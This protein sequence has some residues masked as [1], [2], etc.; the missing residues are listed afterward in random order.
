[1]R[2]YDLY[3]FVVLEL[4]TVSHLHLCHSQTT[5]RDDFIAKLTKRLKDT[6]TAADLRCTIVKGSYPATRTNPILPLK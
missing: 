2:P 4:E 3:L 5:W 6:S 1:M